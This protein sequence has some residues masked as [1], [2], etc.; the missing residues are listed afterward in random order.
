[1]TTPFR[2]E[3]EFHIGRRVGWEGEQEHLTA[4]LQS[5]VAHLG[6]HDAVE[7]VQPVVDLATGTLDLVVVVAAD[8]AAA[9]ERLARTALARSIE[10]AGA[11]HHGLLSLKEESL[12]RPKLNA[13]AGLRTPQWRHRRLDTARV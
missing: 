10:E 7:G 5:V 9:A 4:H 13:W 6:E 8:G 12:A 2:V 11:V 3:M 1:V